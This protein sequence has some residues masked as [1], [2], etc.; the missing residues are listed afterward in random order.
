MKKKTRWLGLPLLISIFL[1]FTF[2]L[3]P[4]FTTC[5]YA[6]QQLKVYT[7]VNG[8]TL[9]SIAQKFYNDYLQWKKIHSY[10]KFIK[11]PHWIFPGD[12]LVIPVEVEDTV[13][14]A[15]TQKEEPAVSTDTL[16]ATSPAPPA[17]AP[18]IKKEEPAPPVKKAEEDSVIAGENWEFDGYVSGEKD[19]KIIIGQSDIV[20]LDLGKKQNVKALDRYTIYRKDRSIIHPETNEN[21]GNLIRKIGV[22]E[23]TTDV[24]SETCTGRVIMAREPVM[25]GDMIKKQPQ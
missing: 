12:E 11:N 22:L 7:V 14:T 4:A 16:A 13:V 1:P 8:D 5:L 6:K 24:Q 3:L 9:S 20:F 25:V 19:R 23:I 21:L 10:N 2:Y 15:E 18:V 17:P